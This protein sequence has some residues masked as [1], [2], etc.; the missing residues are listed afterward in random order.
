MGTGV[1][2][3]AGVI[4]DVGVGEGNGVGVCVGLGVCV[5]VGVATGVDE[6]VFDET[7]ASCTVRYEGGLVDGRYVALLTANVWPGYSN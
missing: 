1:G 6:G 7:G 2:V 4:V 3:V 5:G